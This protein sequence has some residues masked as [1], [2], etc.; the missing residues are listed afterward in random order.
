MCQSKIR[1]SYCLESKQV[2]GRCYS[3]LETAGPSVGLWP[4][5]GVTPNINFADTGHYL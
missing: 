4:T 5:E 3:T 1:L 2:T